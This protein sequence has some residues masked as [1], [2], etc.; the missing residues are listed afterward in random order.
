MA[1]L[2]VYRVDA[3]RRILQQCV[4]GTRTFLAA[5]IAAEPEVVKCL[6]DLAHA[7]YPTWC[8]CQVTQ[9]PCRWQITVALATIGIPVIPVCRIG[10]QV[11]KNTPL[12]VDIYQEDIMKA[13]KDRKYSHNKPGDSVNYA[14]VVDTIIARMTADDDRRRR[15]PH[16]ARC[17]A[18]LTRLMRTCADP[19]E[20]DVRL[21]VVFLAMLRERGVRIP[22]ECAHAILTECC[23]RT[24]RTC[25]REM[26]DDGSLLF[27]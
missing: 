17:A 21:F 11:P 15:P 16:S 7:M 4:L 27:P 23:P 3:T 10:L 1:T 6:A 22:A 26:R 12:V 2:A 25:R 24:W 9:E 13:D 8:Q 14:H 18:P 5:V 20:L 19:A